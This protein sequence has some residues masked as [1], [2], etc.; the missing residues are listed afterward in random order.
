LNKFKKQIAQEIII[1]GAK[2]YEDNNCPL[3]K[4]LL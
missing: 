3:S 2:E 4:E 1:K